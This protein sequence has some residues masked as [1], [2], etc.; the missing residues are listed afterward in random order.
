MTQIEDF[1]TGTIKIRR[2]N[3]K[4]DYIDGRFVPG[5]SEVIEINASVQSLTGKQVQLLPD[6]RRETQNLNFF[7]DIELR[8]NDQISQTQADV[9]EYLNK[10]YEIHTVEDWSQMTDLPHFKSVG[11]LVDPQG[12]E[13][14]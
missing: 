14:E 7:T 4:G 11:V 13:D 5:R 6:G 3:R 8:V 1:K 10:C 12:S 9:I 2:N